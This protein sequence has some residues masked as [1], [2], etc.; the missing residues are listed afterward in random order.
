[1]AAPAGIGRR[2]A[3]PTIWDGIGHPGWPFVRFQPDLGALD[4]PPR[5][6]VLGGHRASSR[7]QNPHFGPDREVV[8]AGL[9]TWPRHSRARGGLGRRRGAES[10]NR[11]VDLAW[12]HRLA[13][14][15]QDLD[16]RLGHGRLH[17]GRNPLARERPSWPR[18]TGIH[19][20]FDR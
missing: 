15:L 12:G 14:E 16:V 19:A 8:L 4:R 20:R 6:Q 18:Q 10:G 2:G 5:Q 17:G 11:K 3:R 1:M 7:N 13:A 9:R